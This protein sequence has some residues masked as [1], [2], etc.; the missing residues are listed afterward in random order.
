[1]LMAFAFGVMVGKNIETYPA[2]ITGAIPGLIRE[3]I[4]S[5]P[6]DPGIASVQ[7]DVRE[8]RKDDVKLTFYDTLTGKKTGETKGE[9]LPQS[10]QEE[11]SPA[12]EKPAIQEKP[13][14]KENFMVRV[15]SLRDEQKAQDLQKKLSG[16]GYQSMLETREVDRKGTFYR[17]SLRGFETRDEAEKAADLV[18]KKAKVK[19]LV[20]RAK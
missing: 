9:M 3:K 20:V 19:C 11:K 16:M 18:Q 10:V 17:V 6:L 8:A 12:K 13:Q 5:A 4:A 14:A 2:K 15:A 1:M 7:G